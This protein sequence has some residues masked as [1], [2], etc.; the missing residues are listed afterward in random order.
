MPFDIKRL[1]ADRFGENYELHEQ[2]VNPTLVDVFR[3]IGFD[4]VY[5]RGEGAYLWDD[6]GAQYLDMLG[7]FG[8][9]LAAPGVPV[10]LAGLV[11][12]GIGHGALYYASLYYGMSAGAD[13]VE[14]GGKHEAVIG[15]GYLAGPVLAL[16]GTAIGVAPV[17]A[18]LR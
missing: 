1:V 18:T 14:S 5:A 2:Y 10:V 12:F 4:R 17:T 7:G 3:T 11:A 9:V 16:A 6:T 8:V 13:A 15:A